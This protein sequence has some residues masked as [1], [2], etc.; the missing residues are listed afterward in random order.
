MHPIEQVANNTY[1]AVHGESVRRVTDGDDTRHV[2]QT[3]GYRGRYG[4]VRPSRS[5]WKT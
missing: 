5:G 1:T 4:T 2:P 3:T